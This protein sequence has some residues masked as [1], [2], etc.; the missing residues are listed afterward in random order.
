MPTLQTK[1]YRL[2]RFETSFMTSLSQGNLLQHLVLQLE[3]KTTNPKSILPFSQGLRYPCCML[4][5]FMVSKQ[6]KASTC[7]L[8]KTSTFAMKWNCLL[9]RT[10]T[11][12]MIPKSQNGGPIVFVSWMFPK[13]T[14][15]PKSCPLL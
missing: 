3:Q 10:S 1:V 9:N 8:C 13:K 4:V 14:L 6:A 2:R 11:F 12:A 15:N 5:C 7:F